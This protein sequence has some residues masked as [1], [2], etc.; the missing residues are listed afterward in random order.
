MAGSSAGSCRSGRCRPVSSR[1]ASSRP[2][3]RISMSRAW[4]GRRAGRA[5]PRRSRR[6][7]ARRRPRGAR[8]WSTPGSAAQLVDG[9][10]RQRGPD[11]AP[12]DPRLDLGRRSVGDDPAAGHQ[13]DAVGVGVGLLQ[14]VGGEHHR[15]AAAAKSRIVVQNARRASTSRATVGSSST[16]RSRVG[17]EREREP[18]PLGLAAGELLACGGRRCRR[19][20]SAASTSSTG[21][22]SRV[23]R[24]RPSCTSSRTDRSRISAP[25]CSMAPTRPSSTAAR[26]AAARTPRPCRRRGGQAEQHVDRGRLAGAVGAE[27]GDGLAGRR[28]TGRSLARRAPRRTTWPR[29]AARFRRGARRAMA[30]GG[31]VACSDAAPSGAGSVVRSMTDPP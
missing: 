16:S 27:Q 12:P 21:I 9:R 18:H 5:G 7:S 2:A 8:R 23:E 20:R 11:R 6:T 17:D 30:P 13:H 10:R 26:P 25:V 28:P 1:K 24:R 31:L 29:R 3:P 22:G 14:V 19:C 4:G 15:L